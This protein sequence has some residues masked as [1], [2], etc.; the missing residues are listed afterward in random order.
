MNFGD[1][2]HEKE[3]IMRH[4]HPFAHIW[5]VIWV[6]GS[7]AVSAQLSPSTVQAASKPAPLSST[8]VIVKGE[9]F[10][11][12]G[13]FWG[14]VGN[15]T[16]GNNWNKAVKV[17][18]ATGAPLTNVTAITSGSD[19]ACAVNKS[20][21]V[22]CWGNNSSYALGDGTNVNSSVAV[23]V[24]LQDGITPLT[25]IT[26]LTA[27]A[28]HTCALNKSGAVFCWGSNSDG[29]LGMNDDTYTHLSYPTQVKLNTGEFLS[30]VSMITAGYSHTCA[31]TK[32]SLV[33]CWG[34]NSLYE[35]GDGT[36]DDRFGATNVID[37]A[38]SLPLTGIQSISA[39]FFHT[40][41]LRKTGSVVCWGNNDD[42]QLATG[43]TVDRSKA[44][45]ALTA[46]GVMLSN[47]TK[48]SA[49]SDHTCAITKAKSIIC[50][51]A[52]SVGQLGDGTGNIA[53][54]VYATGVVVLQ[55]GAPLTNI[56]H[57]ES[58]ADRTC[59]VDKSGALYCW[60]ENGF[61]QLSDG[62]FVDKNVATP[63]LFLQSTPLSGINDGTNGGQ[64]SCA[65][66]KTGTVMCWGRGADGQ[67]GDGA[68]DQRT[69][70]V[71]AKMADSSALT[72]VT[73]LAA[74]GF[75][76]CVTTKSGQAYCW[77]TNTYGQLGDGTTD[78]RLGA[79]LA[80][81]LNGDPLLNVTA[82]VAGYNHTCTLNK[83]GSVLCWGDNQYGQL[84]DGTTDQRE[85]AVLSGGGVLPTI[86]AIASGSFHTCALAS[87]KQVYCWGANSVGQL[88]NGTDSLSMTPVLVTTAPGVTLTNVTAISAGEAHTC[89]L[90]STKMVYCWGDN[91]NGQVGINEIE[92]QVYRATL[93]EQDNETALTNITA[94][95]AGG[96]HTCAV[97]S[98][99]TYCWG[100][101]ANGQL[102]DKTLLDR[103][104]AIMVK[105]LSDS[106]L[107]GVSKIRLNY[108]HTCA[109]TK[110][111]QI[112]CWGLN[113]DGQL[114]DNTTTKRS[115]AGLVR[116]NT[117]LNITGVK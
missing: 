15:G 48:V 20:G 42:G 2:S 56:Q 34:D 78:Q 82:I 18:L 60:G 17:Q 91:Y 107:V 36:F 97:S 86:T 114:G 90:T 7:L 13:N 64:H 55:G 30:N 51:G 47:I 63:S 75:H 72:G 40:C 31:L 12:G 33:Y 77:G 108:Q 88:G 67:L 11:W 110:T 49:G 87:T 117:P 24:K 65:L 100:K 38:T 93:A 27:G 85:G 98:L 44:V 41:A 53:D 43:D 39:Y 96:D 116:L 80:E 105:Q 57:L 92:N 103:D 94:I 61:G 46:A 54:L 19:F 101:N 95:G 74:G 76:T 22:Y 79:T 59:A 62:T 104:G 106:N 89:A 73:N 4:S 58:S 68:T 115:G 8:C 99:A 35:L 23:M 111:G 9:V 69:G 102:G 10:C 6:L 25:N 14:Q 37:N 50:W 32:T 66:I 21:V 81:L 52:N 29:R 28:G 70:A 83:T 71:V 112:Y 26:A 113:D 1:I 109:I 16:N 5:L 45:P 84:G 3:V